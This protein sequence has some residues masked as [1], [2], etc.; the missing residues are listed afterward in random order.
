[1][2][3]SDP[4]AAQVSD[5]QRQPVPG[6]VQNAARVM[7]AGAAVAVIPGVIYLVTAGATKRAIENA[8]PDVSASTV[9][10]FTY[11]GVIVGALLALTSVIVFVWIARSCLGGDAAE[12]ARDLEI[13]LGFVQAA[14]T[15]YGAAYQD[16]INQWIEA[17][18]QE[19]AKTS[20]A[21][22]AGQAAVKQ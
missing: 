10:T 16:E 22:S 1:M 2:I 3:R 6:S 7:F 18:E 14:I 19:A 4:D 21:W 5:V 15:Y 11:A 20:A 13:P 9:S 8:H 17:N 12:T